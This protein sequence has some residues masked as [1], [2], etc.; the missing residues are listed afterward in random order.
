MEPKTPKK[1]GPAKLYPCHVSLYETPSGLD[2]LDQLARR[3]EMSQAAC[4]RYLIRE[5][6][7]QRGI[8]PG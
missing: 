4:L 2:L 1:R 5:A 8:Q 3:M 7:A 6:A